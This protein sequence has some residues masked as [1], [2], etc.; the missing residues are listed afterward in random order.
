MHDSGPE[1]IALEYCELKNN[2]FNQHSR[3]SH[4]QGNRFLSAAVADH[5]PHCQRRLHRRQKCFWHNS[6]LQGAHGVRSR[7]EN[8]RKRIDHRVLYQSYMDQNLPECKRENI[9]IVD[10]LVGNIAEWRTME[11]VHHPLYIT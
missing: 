4:T 8:H 6:L 2:H 3:L 11:I 7:R 9:R 5:H 10:T 1:I